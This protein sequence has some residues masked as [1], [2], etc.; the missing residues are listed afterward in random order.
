[1][2]RQLRS[3][4]SAAP[5]TPAT[6]SS[7]SRS[8]R[9]SP[10]REAPLPQPDDNEFDTG[11]SNIDAL[12][13]IFEASYF[14][15]ELTD[16][17]GA[18]IYPPAQLYGAAQLADISRDYTR[19]LNLAL[20]NLRIARVRLSSAT[21]QDSLQLRLLSPDV[22]VGSVAS[23]TLVSPTPLP[24]ASVSASAA[25]KAPPSGARPR[26]LF[27]EEPQPSDRLLRSTS[28]LR[29]TRQALRQLE[30]VEQQAELARAA[31]AWQRIGHHA[32]RDYRTK[33][34]KHVAAA[35]GEL[36]ALI[37]KTAQLEDLAPPVPGR[38]SPPA[39]IPASLGELPAIAAEE[40]SQID[41]R[42]FSEEDFAPSPLRV[43]ARARRAESQSP[44][45]PPAKRPAKGKPPLPDG[46]RPTTRRSPAN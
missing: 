3:S 40:A 45:A 28:A 32:L 7:A 10:R 24:A 36:R 30:C 20:V 37:R 43:K 16:G 13:G 44:E 11:L 2:S 23:F 19:L 26:V 4:E 5:V 34:N 41:I 22:D 42:K 33:A 35:S 25:S 29:L 17:A 12:V 14:L 18:P 27:S 38:K 46:G 6:P 1:M 9:K 15:A 31:I 8:A 21:S 39:Q